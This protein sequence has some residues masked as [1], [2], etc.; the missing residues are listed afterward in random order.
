MIVMYIVMIV[1]NIMCGLVSFGKKKIWTMRE[2]ANPILE[3]S[4]LY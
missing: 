2:V 3:S 4:R 1:V